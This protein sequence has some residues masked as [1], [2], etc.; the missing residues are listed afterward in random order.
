MKKFFAWVWGL[1]LSTGKAL[2]LTIYILVSGYT[3]LLT[4][5]ASMMPTRESPLAEPLGIDVWDYKGWTFV[6]MTESVY[7]LWAIRLNAYKEST[8][9]INAA[10]LAMHEQ[11][12]DWLNIAL[13]GS[14]FGGAP[15]LYALGK[16]KKRPGDV[17]KEDAEKERLAAGLQD[18][19]DFKKTLV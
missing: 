4:G 15:A 12:V 6:F 5:C 7:N 1:L 14:L 19:E 8:D 10:P 16:K 2:L 18:P 17:T 13:S 3:V 9:L 11:A